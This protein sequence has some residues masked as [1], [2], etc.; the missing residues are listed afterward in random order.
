MKFFTV[1]QKGTLF[2]ISLKHDPSI[3]PYIRTV[4]LHV[5]STVPFRLR[6]T[7]QFGTGTVPQDLIESTPLP[8]PEKNNQ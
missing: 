7:V 6:L 5:V 1:L 2:L 4:V 3:V 8:K